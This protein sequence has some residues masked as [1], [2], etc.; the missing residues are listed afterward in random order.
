MSSEETTGQIEV[1]KQTAKPKEIIKISFSLNMFENEK[2]AIRRVIF[3][4]NAQR[5][6][7]NNINGRKHSQYG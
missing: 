1:V 6:E 7:N 5:A 3:Q 4:G 2:S